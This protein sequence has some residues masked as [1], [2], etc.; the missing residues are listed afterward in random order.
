MQGW[1][2]FVIC[3]SIALVLGLVF[4]I[5]MCTCAGLITYLIIFGLISS[6]VL[7]GTMLLINIYYTGPMNHPINALRVKYLVFMEH[8]KNYL[9]V[10]AVV[11]ILL[12]ILLLIFFIKKLKWIR[13]TT[14]MLKVAAVFSLKNV[15]LLFL[16]LFIIILQILVFFFEMYVI[17][18]IYTSGEEIRDDSEG[19]PF[20]HYK[21]TSW[22]KWL[23]FFNAFGTYWLIIVLNNF[24]DFVCA[25]ITVNN[26]FQTD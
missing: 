1:N 22:N 9:I 11:F 23:M 19:S 26:Y 25:A 14:P 24:N 12:G 2:L 8:N 13:E 15:L 16:S 6:L 10:L 4:L 21:M 7:L 17:L 5:L 3:S 20:V 18:R